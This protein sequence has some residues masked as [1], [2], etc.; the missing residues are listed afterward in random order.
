LTSSSVVAAAIE[1]SAA[2]RAAE[3]SE[4]TWMAFQMQ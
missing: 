4:S 1:T 2:S 3:M